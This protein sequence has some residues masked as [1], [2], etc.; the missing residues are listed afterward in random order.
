MKK[1]ERILKSGAIGNGFEVMENNMTE[2]NVK[3]DYLVRCE[4]VD[5]LLSY[6]RNQD[7]GNTIHI[8]YSDDFGWIFEEI[9]EN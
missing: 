5:S 2:E 1:Y 9:E 3:V 4:S 7:T 6:Y 8:C